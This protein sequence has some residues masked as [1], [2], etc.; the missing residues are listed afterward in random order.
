MKNVVLC[1]DRAGH[2]P[3]LRDATN[4]ERLFR[5]LDESADQITWYDA[6][7]RA[8]DSSG[9]HRTLKWRDAATDDADATIAEAYDF[10][11][12]WWE[13]GDRIYMFGVGRGAYCAQ[14][15]TRML[16]TVG[17]EP[18]F[19]DYVLAAY[20]VPRTE[21][22]PRDW[23]RV[24]RLFAELSGNDE[25]S[26]P[27]SFLGLWDAMWLPG[28]RRAMPEPLPNVVVGRHAVAIDGPPG[29]R[30]VASACDRIEEVWFR[31][32]HCDVV[33]GP[34]ACWPLADLTL[35]WM[36]DGAIRAGASV[37]ST[38][39]CAAPAPQEYDALAGSART[40]SIRKLP[41]DA[42]V[43]SSVNIYLR[44]HPAYWRRLPSHVIW[45]D[46]NWTARAERLLPAAKTTRTI[47]QPALA[48]VAS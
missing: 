46:A 28:L 14:I 22:T 17:L 3:G 43:H 23:Q 16:G 44:E 37:Q 18:D 40:I 21:R 10:L 4:A 41:A 13:P 7:M 6:G 15:L 5:L 36:L 35:D 1:F 34:G 45:A 2:H 27:V 11:I 32:A 8:A 20:R 42:L 9:L 48:A 31:G 33:G 38:R 12:D 19:K 26:V 30:L 24:A 29:E 47:E 25:I 39:R